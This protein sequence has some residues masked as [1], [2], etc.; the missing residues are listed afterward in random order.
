MLHNKVFFGCL[1]CFALLGCNKDK[2]TNRK[3]S[4]EWEITYY[5]LTH[6]DNWIEF[7]NELSGSILLKEDKQSSSN[8]FNMHISYAFPSTIGSQTIIGTFEINTH[9]EYLTVLEYDSLTQTTI[10]L[11]YRILTLTKTDLQLE[12]R[13][14]KN[15]LHNYLFKKVE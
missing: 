7:A 5:K 10:D 2:R 13:D 15:Y 14:S 3:I 8:G 6:S 1:L 11:N 12:I 4:G 9:G